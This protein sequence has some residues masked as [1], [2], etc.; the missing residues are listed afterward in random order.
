[1]SEITRLAVRLVCFL[2]AASSNLCASRSASVRLVVRVLRFLLFPSASVK[3]AVQ[4]FDFG[5]RQ[6]EA[7]NVRTRVRTVDIVFY[8]FIVI[9]VQNYNDLR[10]IAWRIGSTGSNPVGVTLSRKCAVSY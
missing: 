5:C 1:M 6:M 3:Q 7:I 4:Y 8:V 2:R 10:K 9:F